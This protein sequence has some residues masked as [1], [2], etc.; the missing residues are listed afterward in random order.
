MRIGSTLQPIVRILA[1]DQSI[2]REFGYDGGTTVS[3]FSHKFAKGGTYY[4]R[5]S[6]YESSGRAS[7][8][9]R[10]LVGKLPIA[11]SAYPLGIHRG[12]EKQVSLTGYNLGAASVTVK[13]TA[14]PGDPDLAIFRPEAPS[15]EAFT[16]VKLALGDDP[17]VET[18]GTAQTVTLPVTINGR[19][20]APGKEHVYRFPRRRAKRFRSKWT[21]GGW[22]PSSI[23]LSKFSTRRGSRSSGWWR[24]RLGKPTWCCGTMIRKPVGC[25]F[26]LRTC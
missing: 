3:R 20:A 17:E 13:G 4:L 1:V 7:H 25:V 22:A 12:S 11:I 23:R 16:D 18:S 19:I 24:V 5:I 9:Y 2:V 6:D 14:A 8:F 10:I 21:H 26:R 15:G